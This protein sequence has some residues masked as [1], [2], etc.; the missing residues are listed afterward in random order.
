MNLQEQHE[1]YARYLM[2]RNLRDLLSDAREYVAD[3]LEAHEHSD[4]RRLLREIDLALGLVTAPK[5]G[6]HG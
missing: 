5:G 6:R 3:A 1:Q 4:G 2:V